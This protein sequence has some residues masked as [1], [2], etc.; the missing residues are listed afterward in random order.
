MDFRGRG[1]AIAFILAAPIPAQASAWNPEPWHGELITSF[2]ETTATRG[3]DEFGREV[4]LDV[5]RKRT[6]QN[7]GIAGLTKRIALVGAFDWQDAQIVGPSLDVS[8]RAPSKMEAGLQYQLH[9]TDRRAVAVSVSY[10]AGA[11][12]PAALLTLEGRRDRVELRG[13]WGENYRMFGRDGF[14]EGQLAG[15]MEL[16]GRISGSRAQLSAGLKPF[17]RT[18]VILKARY[19][20]QES[21]LFERLE[22]RG[23]QRWEAEALASLNLWKGAFLEVG[24][25]GTVAADNAVLEHGFKLGT[26][27]KF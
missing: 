16:G 7:Y 5:Y 12:L 24:Y 3:V 14:V 10:L 15:R 8:F 4:E 1:A 22:L 25:Q 23:Q 17:A 18:E 9:R 19:A 2:V 26:W 13:L 20:R 27:T 21:G 11:D 6:S